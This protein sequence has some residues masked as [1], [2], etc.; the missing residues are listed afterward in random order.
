MNTMIYIIAWTQEFRFWMTKKN[1]SFFGIVVLGLKE[2]I[3]RQKGVVN[4]PSCDELCETQHNLGIYK[5]EKH[6]RIEFLH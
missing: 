6:L 3:E 4:I 5:I 2:K 1:S